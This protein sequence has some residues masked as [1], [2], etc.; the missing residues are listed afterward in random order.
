MCRPLNRARKNK[1]A[2]KKDKCHCRRVFYLPYLFAVYFKLKETPI[3]KSIDKAVKLYSFLTFG[4]RSKSQI[5]KSSDFKLSTNSRWWYSTSS[6]VGCTH[7]ATNKSGCLTSC[8]TSSYALL[9][10][11]FSPIFVSGTFTGRRANGMWLE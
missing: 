3:V 8:T 7:F 4:L 11:I 1:I 6:H 5:M 9:W 10:Y 2:T